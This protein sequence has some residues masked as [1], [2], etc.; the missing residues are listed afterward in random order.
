M[1]K[2][3]KK[4]LKSKSKNTPAQH[5]SK[6]KPQPPKKIRRKVKKRIHQNKSIDV[7]VLGK[8]NIDKSIKENYLN[9]FSPKYQGKS[10][11]AR[12]QLKEFL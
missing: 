2:I 6:P 10:S 8:K 12:N 9:L 7:N 5:K 1:Q 11:K 3:Q 4:V